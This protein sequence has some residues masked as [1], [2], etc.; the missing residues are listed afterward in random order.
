[1]RNEEALTVLARGAE[2]AVAAGGGVQVPVPPKPALV[3][4]AHAM[5]WSW[6]GRTAKVC[7]LRRRACFVD[8][9]QDR[10]TFGQKLEL[11]PRNF[12]GFLRAD[13]FEDSL[14]VMRLNALFLDVGGDFLHLHFHDGITFDVQ[15]GIHREGAQSWAARNTEDDVKAGRQGADAGAGA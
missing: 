10:E 7:V 8:V 1:M 11:L 3:V 9:S 15:A 13:L 4:Y 2:A 6:S 5:P 12:S 14:Y